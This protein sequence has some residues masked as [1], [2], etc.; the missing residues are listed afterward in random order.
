MQ[1]SERGRVLAKVVSSNGKGW[2]KANMRRLTEF[3]LCI[4]GPVAVLFLAALFFPVGASAQLGQTSGPGSGALATPLPVSGRT[5]Q[6]GGVIATQAPI[7]GTTTSVTTLNPS[8]QVQ[9]AYARKR[10]QHWENAL[11]REAVAARSRA[12]S[13]RI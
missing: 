1:A 6:S 3:I 7:P 13:D 9:G 8:V 10:Q 5:S 4:G 2:F 11:Q 12:A